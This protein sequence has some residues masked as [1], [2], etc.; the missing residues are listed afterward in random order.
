MTTEIHLDDIGTAF[1]ITLK[2]DDVIVDLQATTVKNI[3]FTKPTVNGI[4]GETVTKEAVF[5]TNGTDGVI[6]YITIADDLD[7]LGTW[8]IQAFITLPTGSWSSSIEKFKVY[9]NL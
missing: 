2:D 4:A 8:K 7:V 6:Q 1:R 9:E 3:I 5:Y